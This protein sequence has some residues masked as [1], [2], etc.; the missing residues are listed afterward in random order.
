[1]CSLNI[2]R[3]KCTGMI[4][5]SF[6]SHLGF[7]QAEVSSGLTAQ[8]VFQERRWRHLEPGL[9]RLGRL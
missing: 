9:S 5:D 4:I 7:Q 6:L 1:M 8:A 2:L 3:W